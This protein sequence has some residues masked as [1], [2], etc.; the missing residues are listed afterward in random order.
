[1]LWFKLHVMT[2][3]FR[4]SWFSVYISLCNM[5]YMAMQKYEDSFIITARTHLNCYSVLHLTHKTHW[6]IAII[7]IPYIRRIPEHGTVLNTAIIIRLVFTPEG[8]RGR[9]LRRSPHKGTLFLQVSQPDP[10]PAIFPKIAARFDQ[11]SEK[12]VDFH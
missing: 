7:I 3:I 2:C 1:M 4:Y 12:V 6:C 5:C 8:E 9:L 10:D 11:T